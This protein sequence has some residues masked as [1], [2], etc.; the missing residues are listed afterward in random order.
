MTG[1]SGLIG[2]NLVAAYLR[3]RIP[4]V[5]LDH[6]PPRVPAHRSV[7]EEVD[8]RDLERLTEPL[9]TFAPTVVVHLAA[10]TDLRGRSIEDYSPNTRGVENLITAS[11]VLSTPPILFAS[12]RLVC[13]IGYVPKHDTDW[14]PSTHYGNSQGQGRADRARALQTGALGDRSADFN[15]GPLVRCSVPELLRRRPRRPISAAQAEVIRKS[16]GY[17]DNTVHQ[18][19]ELARAPED[20]VAGRVFYLADYSRW[21]SATCRRDCSSSRPGACTSCSR[22]SA[23][24]ARRRRRSP[25][26]PRLVGASAD[27]VQAKQSL[28]RNGLRLGAG[29]ISGRRSPVPWVEGVSRTVRWL[30]GRDSDSGWLPRRRHEFGPRT[31]RVVDR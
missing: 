24:S 23:S 31:K 19:Q 1:G 14:R 2:T 30:G 9:R 4:V 29:E 12:S 5:S 13:E 16:F 26:A 6:R 8:I 25:A 18:L 3:E 7:W 22:R 15:L 20:S 11:S 17:V 10:R 28:L 21:R 27:V